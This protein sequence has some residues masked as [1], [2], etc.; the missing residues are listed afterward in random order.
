[1]TKISASRL[2]GAVAAI[3][4][5]A[6]RLIVAIELAQ[7]GKNVGETKG[8]AHARNVTQAG[9]GLDRKHVGRP[10]R[11][12]DSLLRV[13]QLWIAQDFVWG[14]VVCG[15]MK[16]RKFRGIQFGLAHRSVSLLSFPV[17]RLGA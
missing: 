1:M 10:G 15:R 9:A 8:V 17:R 5:L 14:I 6:R 11:E 16:Q 13:G 2:P 7:G 3:A 4:R 12:D